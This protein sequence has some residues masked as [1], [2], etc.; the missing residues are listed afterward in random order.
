MTKE[1]NKNMSTLLGG[2]DRIISFAIGTPEDPAGREAGSK[3]KIK[4]ENEL[5][6][7]QHRF[8]DAGDFYFIAN[9]SLNDAR[10][11]FKSYGRKSFIFALKDEKSGE[12]SYQFWKWDES[13]DDFEVSA[14]SKNVTTQSDAED[15]FAGISD[16][17]ISF[18]VLNDS[19]RTLQD[20][21]EECSKNGSY[22][23]HLHRQ[24][25]H[26]SLRGFDRM[27]NR[28][29]L[30]ETPERKRERE[31][32]LKKS[33][34][35][36]RNFESALF[37]RNT[38]IISFAIAAPKDPKGRELTPEDTLKLRK[39][40]EKSLD[41]KYYKYM[42]IKEKLRA[43]KEDLYFI[44]N[45]NI[46]EIT[47]FFRQYRADSFVFAIK[48]EGK[49]SGM[50]Y[51]YWKRERNGNY[52]KKQDFYDVGTEAEVESFFTSIPDPIFYVDLE[53]LQETALEMYERLNDKDEDSGYYRRLKKQVYG[54]SEEP[55]TRILERKHMYETPAEET[56]T[57]FIGEHQ[58]FIDRGDYI[59]L[60]KPVVIND[61][62]TIHA[63]EKYG[64]PEKVTSPSEAFDYADKLNLEK[65]GGFSDWRLPD[66]EELLYLKSVQDECGINFKGGKYLPS[67]ITTMFWFTCLLGHPENCAEGSQ[68]KKGYYVICV[69]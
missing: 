67:Y 19:I 10:H 56:R 28:Y 4:F 24:V 64:L 52:V 63:I 12:L 13:G 65:F 23:E 40:F 38:K 35:R 20:F 41:H 3:V 31:E 57:E 50:N 2:D 61:W 27:L 48:E 11:L 51:Q 36:S 5:K 30:Y 34:S 37:G 59:E 68:N 25:Y 55:L 60:A 18:E 1:E 69:R 43:G 39:D 49:F 14:E 29:F 47:A 16:F 6:E 15:F 45:P 22:Y 66:R 21:L 58:Q 33:E 8:K 42:P 54:D 26:Q 53:S 9:P 46:D 32:R 17:K 7:L 62:T 44:I